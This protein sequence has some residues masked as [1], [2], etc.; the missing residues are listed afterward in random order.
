[1]IG[2][3]LGLLLALAGEG[4]L[5]GHVYDQAGGRRQGCEPLVLDQVQDQE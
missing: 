2:P 4:R 3:W 5:G 1:M